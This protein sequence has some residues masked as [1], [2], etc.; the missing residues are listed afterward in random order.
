MNLK[1]MNKGI[2]IGIALAIIIG[3]SVIVVSGNNSVNISDI[4]EVSIEEGNKSEP[5]RF[6][7]ELSESIGF[8]EN[9][10]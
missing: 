5:N 10:P 8:S 2:I 4:S 7:I 3:V 6:T 1:Y 9:R